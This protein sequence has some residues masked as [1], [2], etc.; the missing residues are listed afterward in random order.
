[1][2][3]TGRMIRHRKPLPFKIFNKIGESKKAG[4]PGGFSLAALA[5]FRT[6][7]ILIF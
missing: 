2:H 3:I 6:P 4:G 1:M 7:R 5:A